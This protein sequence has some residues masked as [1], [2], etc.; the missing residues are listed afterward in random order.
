[1]RVFFAPLVLSLLACTGTPPPPPAVVA[2]SRPPATT[3]KG[4]TG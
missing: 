4:R 1:M 2:P 3:E